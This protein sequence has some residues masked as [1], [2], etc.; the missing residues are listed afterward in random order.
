MKEFLTEING[1]IDLR[2]THKQK[3]NDKHLY[4]LISFILLITLMLFIHLLFKGKKGAI[5]NIPVRK[6]FHQFLPNNILKPN[7]MNTN[8]KSL[9]NINKNY[10]I[11]ENEDKEKC[12]LYTENENTKTCL[13]CSLG[14][15]LFEG[16]C[17]INYSFKAIYVTSKRNENIYFINNFSNDIKEM[18]VDDK[19]VKPCKNFTFESI[20]YHTIYVLIDISK[21]DSLDYMFYKINHLVS[22]SF[23]EKF[24]TEKIKSMS[25]FFSLCSSLKNINVF[26]FETSNVVDMSY[27]FSG[28]PLIS[29]LN[30]SN[31]IT[32]NVVNMESMFLGCSSLAFIDISNFNTYNV[33]NM[34]NMFYGCSS[35][36]K[37]E[38]YSFNTE[39]VKYMDGMFYSCASLTSINISNFNIKNV[40]DMNNMFY[41]CS[42]LK[43]L[44]L[45]NL[46]AENLID[47][48]YM[49]S[50]CS[51]LNSVD[52]TKL[53]IVKLKYMIK[54]FYIWKWNIRNSSFF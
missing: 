23:S 44:D 42:K 27:M 6:N 28:C 14:Y 25:Y 29:N 3:K 54:T 13:K 36:S 49:F 11:D 24:N 8:Y 4:S 15:K 2:R 37:I 39:N 47:M 38:L 26:N 46:N 45:S 52:F 34:N 51:S 9:E 19:E 30:I 48:S 20:G 16:E 7:Y 40:V 10:L 33:N 12:I 18:I 21:L 53:K 5:N 22:I 50:G 32:K 43:S 35:L 41:G 1:K 17:I 31:F